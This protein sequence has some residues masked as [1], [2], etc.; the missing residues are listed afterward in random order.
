MAHIQKK[1]KNSLEPKKA[2]WFDLLYFSPE[3]SLTLIMDSPI[4]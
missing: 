1:K 2:T 4:L 3:L